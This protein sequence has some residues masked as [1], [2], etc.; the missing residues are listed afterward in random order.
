MENIVSFWKFSHF[1]FNCS[2][3]LKTTSLPYLVWI[4]LY[5]T[6]ASL[7]VTMEPITFFSC[8]SGDKTSAQH[9]TLCF[10]ENTQKFRD[11]FYTHFLHEKYLA[12]IALDRTD[13]QKQKC[14]ILFTFFLKHSVLISQARQA[15]TF[16]ILNASS[17]P[18][19][20]EILFILFY[21]RQTESTDLIVSTHTLANPNNYVRSIT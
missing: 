14:I 20:S 16:R 18:D 9:S 6:I 4:S 5:T 12:F 3:R 10:L 8:S 11:T 17:K 7:P 15:R 2:W 13:E 19:L 21:G 1:C